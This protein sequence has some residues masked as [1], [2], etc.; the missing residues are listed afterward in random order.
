MKI[1]EY[2][3]VI[4]KHP[5][6]NST[7]VNFPFDVEKEFGS[8]V[9]HIVEGVSKLTHLE[10]NSSSQKQAK[11]FQKLVFAMS[12]DMRVMIIKLADRLHN[13]RTIDSM[14]DEKKI[15]NIIWQFVV[16]INMVLVNLVILFKNKLIK[17]ISKYS[18]H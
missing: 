12:K 18:F 13:M 17:L 8:Q 14:S 4:K 5:N 11:N 1:Y 3:T 15:Q 16:K 7:Y 9:A 10:F 6:L 2:D